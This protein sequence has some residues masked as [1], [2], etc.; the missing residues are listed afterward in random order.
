[1][2]VSKKNGEVVLYIEAFLRFNSPLWV[3]K[4]YPNFGRSFEQ[5]NNKITKG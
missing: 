5:K 2:K 3:Y 1:M 4:F